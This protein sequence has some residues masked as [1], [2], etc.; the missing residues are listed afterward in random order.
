MKKIIRYFTL[1]S[2]I[3]NWIVLMVEQ[4]AALEQKKIYQIML[5]APDKDNYIAISIDNKNEIIR[6]LQSLL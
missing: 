1:R 2:R 4:R 5:D 6:I 3:K